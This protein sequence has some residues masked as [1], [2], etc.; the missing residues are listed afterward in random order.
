MRDVGGV[1]SGSG[2]FDEETM[3]RL[4]EGDFDPDEFTKAMESAYGEGYYEGEDEGLNSGEIGVRDVVGDEVD[5]DYDQMGDGEEED[6][7][8]QYTG[9]GGGGGEGDYN[10]NDDDGE[11]ED[12]DER[13]ERHQVV[14]SLLDDLYKLDYEDLIGDTPCRFKYR[15]VEKNDYGLSAR[16]ILLARDQDLN[17]YVSLKKLVPFREREEVRS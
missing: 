17:Q 1:G 5:Y 16:D 10:N 15:K 8:E 14:N 13:E 12:E 9:S 4:L 6:D 3:K 2:A 7:E 11:E